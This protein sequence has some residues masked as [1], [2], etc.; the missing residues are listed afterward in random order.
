MWSTDHQVSRGQRENAL[1]STR[2]SAT[3]MIC[4]W[5]T[6]KAKFWTSEMKQW[7]IHMLK[8]IYVSVKEVTILVGSAIIC[9]V[10]CSHRF[11]TFIT[12]PIQSTEFSSNNNNFIYPTRML[13]IFHFSLSLIL[14]WCTQPTSLQWFTY[15]FVESSRGGSTLRTHYRRPSVCSRR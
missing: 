14:W 13:F 11:T 3:E 10:K 12:K 6:L 8:V 1:Y 9:E 2:S 4:R 15:S 7:S 5:P